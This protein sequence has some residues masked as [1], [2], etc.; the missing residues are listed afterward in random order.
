[1]VAEAPKVIYQNKVTA[2]CREESTNLKKKNSGP[3]VLF[4][5]KSPT[6]ETGEHQASNN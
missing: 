3:L 2:V 4:G 1:M 5:A 6:L